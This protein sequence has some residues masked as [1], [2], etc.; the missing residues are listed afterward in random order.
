M[1]IFNY[2][3]GDKIFSKV[4]AKRLQLILPKLINSDQTA[5]IKGRNL[6]DNIRTVWDL[7]EV[8]K[9]TKK[10]AYILFI[11]F[12]KAFDS[13]SFDF[14]LKCLKK[15]NLGSFVEHIKTQEMNLYIL[16]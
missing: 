3:Y 1:H 8:S 10:S 6:S 5:Y 11:D 9:L 15:C 16:I 13:V 14:L 2:R 4:L 12:E 7:I